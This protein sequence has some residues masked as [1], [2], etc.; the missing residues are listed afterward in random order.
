[1]SDLAG[2]VGPFLTVAATIFTVE[3]T[4]KDALLLLS[5]AT[6]RSARLVF[7]AGSIA[8]TMTSAVIVLVGSALVA[9]VPILW[10][11]FAGGGIM[12]AYGLWTYLGG[13]RAERR[14]EKDEEQLRRR[15]GRGGRYA[16]VA[17]LLSLAVLD[18]AGDATELLTI[19]FV[20]Q[21]RNI[22]L[23]FL[24]AVAA[25][26]TASG[27]ETVLGNRLGRILSARRARYLSTA[28][29]LAIGTVVVVTSALGI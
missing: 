11:K 12:V 15:G 9:Y 3:L 26:V 7:A 14:I 2:L 13:L 16:F 24:G 28:V 29:L 10:I 27:L 6:T 21:Y 19:L 22:V 23:V 25:L 4:D 5:L 8:F 1:L 20:A 17:M 18:L